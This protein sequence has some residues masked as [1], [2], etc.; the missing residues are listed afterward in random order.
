MKKKVFYALL[1]AFLMIPNIVF[2]DYNLDYVACGNAD[3]IP[4]PVPQMT[5][6]LYT[7]L[8]IATPIILII[9]GIITLV[10]AITAGDASE[11]SKAKGKLIKKF[12]A[13]GVVFFVAG[14]V[15]FIIT[16]AADSRE[17]GSIVDC[18][19]CFLYYDESCIDSDYENELSGNYNPTDPGTVRDPS[20]PTGNKGSYTTTYKSTTSG[21]TFK[22]YSQVDPVWKDKK[23]DNSDVTIGDNGCMITSIAVLASA[24]EGS[25]TPLTVFTDGYRHSHPY[26]AVPPLSGNKYTCTMKSSPSADTIK[27]NLQKGNPVIIKVYGS[28]NGGSSKFTSSQHY[29]ALID[30]NSDGSKIYVGNAYSSSTYGQSGW[31]SSSDVLTSVQTAEICVP[32][33]PTQT[34]TEPTNPPSGNQTAKADGTIFVGDSRTVG[35]CQYNNTTLN[36]GKCRDYLTVSQGGMGYN[37][38]KSTAI[39]K[40]DTLL[41]QNSNKTFNIVILLGVNDIS[42]TTYWADA[43]VKEYMT[44]I[45]S[46]ASGTWKNHNIIFTSVTPLG[47][48]S[49]GGDWPVTQTNIDYFNS[50]MKSQINASGLSNVSYCDINTGLDLTGK[51]AGDNIHYTSDGYTAVY[52]QVVNKCL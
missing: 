32:K 25:V 50:Q 27:E 8:V 38:F 7:L 3:G 46:K 33:Q 24:Y 4:K 44:Q 31:F 26:T 10:K 14:I 22:I 30:I 49:T 42:N 48:E 19:N 28:S 16:Q 43:A 1:I 12:I 2:A 52:N 23:Y 6:I 34:Q 9:F 41:S 5:S 29:M 35:I 17:K 15:Q 51:I 11:I 13:A 47:A 18:I 21:L 20:T 36:V 45:K 37:W 39:S 40:V